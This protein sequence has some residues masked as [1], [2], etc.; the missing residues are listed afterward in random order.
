MSKQMFK[1]PL[2]IGPK[3]VLSIY[4]PFRQEK[5]CRRFYRTMRDALSLQPHQ[6]VTINQF[7]NYANLTQEEAATRLV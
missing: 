3:E 2:F 5:W 7:L 1:L 6:D 4:Y